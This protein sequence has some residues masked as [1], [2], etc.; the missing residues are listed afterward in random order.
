MGWLEERG[1]IAGLDDWRS[2]VPDAHHD[3]LEQR[4]PA[5][6]AY[7]PLGSQN[8]KRN[9]KAAADVLFGLY[10]QGTKTNRNAWIY[11]FDQGALEQ[12]LRGVI[13]FYERRRCAVARGELTV[14]EATRNDAPT[15]I[16]WDGSLRDRFGRDWSL[17]WRAQQMRVGHYRPFVKQQFYFD[18]ILINSTYRMPAFFPTAE[19]SNQAISVTGRGESAPFST[20]ISDVIPNLHLIAGAQW[21]ARWRYEA[22]DDEQQAA[23]LPDDAGDDG[24]VSGYRRV[25]NLTDWGLQQFRQRYPALHITKDDVWHYIYG[26]LHTPDYREKYR[27][28][29]SKDLPRIPFAPD[30]A[31]F[32]RAGEQ[33]AAL[34]LGYETCPEYELS[35][36]VSRKCRPIPIASMTRT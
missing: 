19:A 22:V 6:Q 35:V 2:I 29:L 15:K 5:Y 34:H 3:W 25:D 9:P 12:R 32:C 30:F 4:D 28:D 20:L 8:A 24:N 26:L 11:G 31:A 13:D 17:E 33:L 7:L 10:S 21:F 27:A 14:D 36:Q 23:L 18:R 16:R 1:S